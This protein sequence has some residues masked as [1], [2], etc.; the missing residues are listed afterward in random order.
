MNL[1]FVAGRAAIGLKMNQYFYMILALLL[2]V[3]VCFLAWLRITSLKEI[4]NRNKEA[5]RSLSESLKKAR[6]PREVWCLMRG[7]GMA[8]YAAMILITEDGMEIPPINPQKRTLV[9]VDELRRDDQYVTP[10]TAPSWVR[11]TSSKRS[12]Y[13]EISL[14]G[15]IYRYP[16]EKGKV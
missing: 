2:F 10:L 7:E 6:K 3:V 14:F 15:A 4:N 8:D 1:Y 16:K 11:I 12:Q 5:I 13:N 9:R